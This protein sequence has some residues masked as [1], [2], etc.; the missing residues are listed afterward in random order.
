MYPRQTILFPEL[1]A[2]SGT[3]TPF[4]AGGGS[5][6]L[7]DKEDTID[8]VLRMLWVVLLY[9]PLHSGYGTLQTCTGGSRFAASIRLC[10]VFAVR[11]ITIAE[12]IRLSIDCVSMCA[13]CMC[14]VC[15]CRCRCGVC[16]CVCECMC[17]CVRGSV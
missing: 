15:V 3:Q 13:T 5:R 8:T 6:Y 9:S 16:V 14:G 2:Q 12:N 11:L 10:R 4:L 7:T 1:L 17:A